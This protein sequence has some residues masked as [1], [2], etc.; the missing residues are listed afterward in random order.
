MA[1]FRITLEAARVNVGLSQKQAA[2]LIGV[3]LS[4]LKNYENGKTRP[5]WDT[6]SKMSNTYKI[7]IGMLK[8]T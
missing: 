6:L 2:P 5:N 8:C 1:Q 7:P 4:T 3:S